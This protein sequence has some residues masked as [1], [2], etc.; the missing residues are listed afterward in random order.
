MTSDLVLLRINGFINFFK[1]SLLLSLYI[2]K[3][4]NLLLLYK[5][6]GITKSKID[7]NS[8]KLFSIGVPVRANL[9]LA[10]TFFTASVLNAIG[11][12]IF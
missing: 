2:N 4:W 1:F 7:H 6:P 11:F 8:I 10:L 9:T 5:Y 12:F 3:S